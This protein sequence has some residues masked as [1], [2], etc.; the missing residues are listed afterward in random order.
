VRGQTGARIAVLDN[1]KPNAGELQS[2]GPSRL[3]KMYYFS[4]PELTPV[5]RA[6]NGRYLWFR[7]ERHL[8]RAAPTGVVSAPA[9][10]HCAMTKP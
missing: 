3:S 8:S 4:G 5:A 2:N 10:L 6:L 7:Q 1:G 9:M